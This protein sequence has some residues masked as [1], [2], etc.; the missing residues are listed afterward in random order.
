[1]RVLAQAELVGGLL[2]AISS[3]VGYKCIGVSGAC[4][5]G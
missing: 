2:G 5:G 3:G 1:V 4:C